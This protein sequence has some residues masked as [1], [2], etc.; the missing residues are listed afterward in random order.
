MSDVID[1]N[2]NEVSSYYTYEPDLKIGEALAHIVAAAS[3]VEE[4]EGESE[5]VKETVRKYT[6]AWIVAVAPLDYVP[7]MAEVVGSKINKKL[8]KIFP[9]ISE[10]ELGE[11]FEIVIEAKRKLEEGEVPFNYQ[12]V[13]V[14]TEKVLRALGVDL[15]YIQKFITGDLN[16]RLLRLISIFV[17]A[18]GIA[19]IWDQKWIAEY[20]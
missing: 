20:Q 18:I 9:D 3:I 17:L 11:T 15:S 12:E 6:D 16:K 5:E 14:R 10:D 4:L 1:L 7:G 19:S 8:T 2:S 13:E